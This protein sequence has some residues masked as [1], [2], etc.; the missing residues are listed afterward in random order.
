[1]KPIGNGKI[2]LYLVYE[3]SNENTRHIKLCK[4]NAK[5]KGGS[6]LKD[7]KNEHCDDTFETDSKPR[8]IDIAMME[9]TIYFVASQS[10]NNT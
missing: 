9:V 4:K 6:K 5:N 7:E 1:M 10:L 8:I 3:Q 2:E